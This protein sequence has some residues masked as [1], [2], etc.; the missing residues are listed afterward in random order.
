MLIL[1]EIKLGKLPKATGCEKLGPP[2]NLHST[3]PSEGFE[4]TYLGFPLRFIWISAL[5]VIRR[6]P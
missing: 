5:L 4:P 1:E 3:Q 6:C 2:C